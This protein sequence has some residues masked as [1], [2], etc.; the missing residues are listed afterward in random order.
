LRALTGTDAAAQL[1]L[2]E[3]GDAFRRPERLRTL[4]DACECA[5]GGDQGGA[6]YA[7][8]LV[9]ER[10]LLAASGIDAAKIAAGATGAGDGVA[11]AIRAARLE[12]IRAVLDQA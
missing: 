11:A 8:R 2:L 12:R 9:I 5:D 7:P 4:V 6:P 1:A 10:A 3:A